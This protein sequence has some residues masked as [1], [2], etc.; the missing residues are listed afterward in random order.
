MNVWRSQLKEYIKANRLN[1]LKATRIQVRVVPTRVQSI[2]YAV[3]H[4]YEKGAAPSQAQPPIMLT[5]N[6]LYV[7]QTNRNPY[8]NFFAESA[9]A[10]LWY[11]SSVALR[12]LSTRESIS[13]PSS[14]K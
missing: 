14:S 10:N 1:I 3:V 5:E 11:C 7:K 9:I 8:L 12:G 6:L 4:I 2:I 13:E